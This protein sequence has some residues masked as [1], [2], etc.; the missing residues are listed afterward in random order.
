MQTF[1]AWCFFPRSYKKVLNRNGNPI[2]CMCFI[3]FSSDYTSNGLS[4][5]RKI[6]M[7]TILRMVDVIFAILCYFPSRISFC[8]SMQCIYM[9]CYPYQRLT[10]ITNVSTTMAHWLSV[11]VRVYILFHIIHTISYLLYDCMKYRE[12]EYRL[13]AK[14][15]APYNWPV[16]CLEMYLRRRCCY[17]R[18]AVS[19]VH[20]MG[21]FMRKLYLLYICDLFF[22]QIYIHTHTRTCQW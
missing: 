18:I 5:T 16:F 12:K 22:I 9:V 20:Q 1:R 14:H 13:N 17:Y 6:E 7:N 19:R 8:I 4:K 21:Y 11:C 3:F 10:N 2:S 15:T